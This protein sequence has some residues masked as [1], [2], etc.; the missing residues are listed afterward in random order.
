[1][2][3]FVR[4]D[5]GSSEYH[6]CFDTLKPVAVMRFDPISQRAFMTVRLDN[7]DSH[8]DGLYMELDG[9]TA[10]ELATAIRREFTAYRKRVTA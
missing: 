1:M 5:E 9:D 8:S 2:S 6:S 10:S 7:A 3:V 4:V